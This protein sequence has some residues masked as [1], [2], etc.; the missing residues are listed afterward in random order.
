MIIDKL[1]FNLIKKSDLLNLAVGVELD[2]QM[3]KEMDKRSIIV[4][5]LW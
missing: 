2:I 4:L 3:K 5:N 1:Q